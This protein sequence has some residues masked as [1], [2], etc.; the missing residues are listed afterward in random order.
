VR[1]NVLRCSNFFVEEKRYG[2]QH[3]K[4]GRQVPGVEVCCKCGTRKSGGHT[5]ALCGHGARTK[6][7]GL[8]RSRWPYHFYLPLPAQRR[9]WCFWAD[10]PGIQEANGGLWCNGECIQHIGLPNLPIARR[11]I[12]LQRIHIHTRQVERFVG[13]FC[14][15]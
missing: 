5:K 9:H 10:V 15:N 13:L 14:I 1:W 4:N 12:I 7:E 2:Q 11:R 6:Q 3:T 8:C